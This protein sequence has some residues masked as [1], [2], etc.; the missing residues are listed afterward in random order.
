MLTKNDLK[1]IRKVVREEVEVET[2]DLKTE[3][4]SNHLRTRMEV[5]ETQDKIKNLQIQMNNFEKETNRGLK[6]IEKKLATTSNFLD[7]E[8]L[9]T[10]KRVSRIEEHLKLSPFPS[11]S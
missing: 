4:R 5:S 1:E 6:K 8:D 10:K 11:Q 7:R 3:S 9:Q 2:K